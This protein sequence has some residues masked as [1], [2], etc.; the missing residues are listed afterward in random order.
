MMNR[1]TQKLVIAVIAVVIA[2]T[3]ILT[4]LLPM[5]AR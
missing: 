2:V 4:T 3:M 1:K 5:I